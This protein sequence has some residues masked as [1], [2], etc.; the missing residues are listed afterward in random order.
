[1][2]PRAILC[3]S[4]PKLSIPVIILDGKERCVHED[5]IVIEHSEVGFSAGPDWFL[6]PDCLRYKWIPACSRHSG[7]CT[8][9]REC[10]LSWLD[11]TYLRNSSVLCIHICL[12][13][14]CAHFREQSPSQGSPGN[15]VPHAEL[16]PPAGSRAENQGFSRF[17]APASRIDDRP[18]QNK[19]PGGG[20]FDGSRLPCGRGGNNTEVPASIR[21]LLTAN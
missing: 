4:A 3:G 19:I 2:K 5:S 9:G 20:I 13:R 7:K 1:M 21:R 15:R 10:R 18:R 12:G 8:S 16:C 14:A 11:R 17:R 6:R